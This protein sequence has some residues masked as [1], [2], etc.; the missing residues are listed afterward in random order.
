MSLLIINGAPRKK[1]ISMMIANMIRDNLTTSYDYYHLSEMNIKGCIACGG[2][3][4]DNV[5]KLKDELR[6]IREKL[7]NAEEILFI[8]STMNGGLNSISRNYLERLFQFRHNDTRLLQD[9]L[10]HI[11][12]SG[13]AQGQ[14]TIDDVKSYLKSL[15]VKFG[16]TIDAKGP[17]MCYNCGFGNKCRLSGAKLKDGEIDYERM[18][19]LEGN[20]NLKKD[21]KQLIQILN[22]GE[23]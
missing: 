7:M 11:I 14:K 4:R 16:A 6:D 18:P 20:I 2:C 5:C 12:G 23:K 21:I 13:A 8:G 15:H 19:S 10:V 3:V 9:K 17:V 1:G 22:K